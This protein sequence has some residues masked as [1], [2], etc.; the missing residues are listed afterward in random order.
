MDN[1]WGD[2]DDQVAKI[3]AVGHE[4]MLNKYEAMLQGYEEP[5]VEGENVEYV[6]MLYK[7]NGEDK[8]MPWGKIAKKQEKSARKLYRSIAVEA[9]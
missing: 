9:S 2:E 7:P 6:G 1:N 4:V 8:S 3:L 5:I